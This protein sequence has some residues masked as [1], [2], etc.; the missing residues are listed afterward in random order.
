MLNWGRHKGQGTNDTMALSLLLFAS[1][2]SFLEL[3][4]F[5]A[6]V[7]VFH[8]RSLDFRDILQEA[9]TIYGSRPQLLL[10]IDP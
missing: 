7:E 1:Y 3:L 10:I 6:W 9:V 8:V 5:R 2:V 4:G